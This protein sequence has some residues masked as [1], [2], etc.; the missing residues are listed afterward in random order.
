VS[1]PLATWPVRQVDDAAVAALARESR[2]SG[3]VARLL[4]LR[5]VRD[6]GSVRRWL[7]PAI[8]HLHPPELLPDFEAAVARIGQA[9]G[10]R[11][12]ILLWGHDDLDGITSIVIL[13]RLL[14]DLRADVRYYV[15]AK[16]RERHGLNPEIAVGLGRDRN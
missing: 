9:V 7:N 10:R 12:T 5:G 1:E 4:W 14:T 15:P 2:V 6:A 16:G 11:E 13:F 8:E 3:L